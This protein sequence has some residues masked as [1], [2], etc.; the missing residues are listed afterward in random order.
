MKKPILHLIYVA[1]LLVLLYFDKALNLVMSTF[2]HI[3]TPIQYPGFLLFLIGLILIIT[4]E[5]LRKH[6]PIKP[7]KFIK[8]DISSI[9]L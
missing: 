5:I 7:A 6:Y 2:N 8:P 1:A 3:I 4:V 9:P